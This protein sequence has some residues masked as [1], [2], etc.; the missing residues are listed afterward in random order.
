M[1]I[2]CFGNHRHPEFFILVPEGTDMSSFTGDEKRLL[3]SIVPLVQVFDDAPLQQIFD[4]SELPRIL[5]QIQETGMGVFRNAGI[6]AL[7]APAVP[8]A[9]DDIE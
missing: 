8:V 1:K 4:E 5:Q 9:P 6:A 3:D 2:R 7:V